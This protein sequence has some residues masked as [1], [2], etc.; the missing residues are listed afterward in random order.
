MREQDIDS[1]TE[2]MI[3]A[4]DRISVGLGMISAVAH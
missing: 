2:H 4:A 3:E 1:L